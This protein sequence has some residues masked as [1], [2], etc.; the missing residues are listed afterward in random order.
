MQAL[1]LTVNAT[2]LTMPRR[3]LVNFLAGDGG[4]GATRRRMRRQ[5]VGARSKVSARREGASGHHPVAPPRDEMLQL[6]GL[7]RDAHREALFV[8]SFPPRTAVAKRGSTAMKGRRPSSGY[9]LAA[10]GTYE[11]HAAPSA[12]GNSGQS[13][14]GRSPSYGLIVNGRRAGAG[15]EEVILKARK[16]SSAGQGSTSEYR[17]QSSKGQEL[18]PAGAGSRPGSSIEQSALVRRQSSKAGIPPGLSKS[19]SI[20]GSAAKGATLRRPV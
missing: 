19:S 5:H 17:R 14:G 8:P 9:G 2:R 18:N 4:R 6:D 10:D 13:G 1:G 12:S 7:A 11:G 3:H 20:T 15:V 16:R